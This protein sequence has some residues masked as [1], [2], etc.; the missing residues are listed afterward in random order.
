MLK[1]M[2]L[3]VILV[4]AFMLGFSQTV[5]ACTACEESKYDGYVGFAP[6]QMW[7]FNSSPEDHL[8]GSSMDGHRF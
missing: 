8:P 2:I 7:W 5:Y 3:S 6:T 4:F 1:K